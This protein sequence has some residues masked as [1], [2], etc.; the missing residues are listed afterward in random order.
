MPCRQA[1]STI[2]KYQIIALRQANIKWD[3]ISSQLAF[4]K[5]TAANFYKRYER[6][7]NVEIQ[8]GRGRKY[9]LNAREER[10][11]LRIVKRNNKLSAQKVRVLYNTFSA[12]F[13]G[14]QKLTN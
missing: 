5:T 3:I 13:S 9:K 7:G 1:L 2:Q 8:K 14:R 11:L 12:E 10:A 4:K 6:T